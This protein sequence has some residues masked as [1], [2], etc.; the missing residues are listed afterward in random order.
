MRGAGWTKR[1]NCNFPCGVAQ[2]HLLIPII[3]SGVG[4]VGG[5]VEQQERNV[6]STSRSGP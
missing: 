1:P 5:S 3:S 6:S 4:V 2:G